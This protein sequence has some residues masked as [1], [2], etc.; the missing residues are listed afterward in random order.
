MVQADI[1]SHQIDASFRAERDQ[2]DPDK[3]TEI[4]DTIYDRKYNLVSTAYETFK[5]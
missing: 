1:S 2:I 5:E 4:S 3:N